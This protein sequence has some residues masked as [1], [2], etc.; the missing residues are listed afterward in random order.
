MIRTWRNHPS[1]RRTMGYQKKISQT[2]QEEWFKRVNNNLNY[3]LLIIVADEPIGVI[4]CKEVNLKDQY[5]EGGIFIWN[6]QYRNTAV[7]GIASVILINYIFNVI[8]I[9]NKSFVR[10]LKNN[11]TAQQYNKMLGYTLI[12]GQKENRN[13]WYILT[14]EDFN[15]KYKLL[16]KGAANYMDSDNKLTVD[17]E[18]CDLN[19]PEVNASIGNAY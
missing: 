4:N 15:Q 6:D 8:K 17:G 3:Y 5:G 18:V 19:I 1:I 2:E 11:T 9:G 13:Q 14:K 7:P 16:S 10:I 12:P